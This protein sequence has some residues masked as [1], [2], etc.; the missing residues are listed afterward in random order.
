MSS[1]LASLHG[2]SVRTPL[3]SPA[4]DRLLGKEFS[5]GTSTL[6]MWLTHFAEATFGIDDSVLA[7]RSPY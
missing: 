4:G 7:E 5:E 1:S 2:R 3:Y 6:L